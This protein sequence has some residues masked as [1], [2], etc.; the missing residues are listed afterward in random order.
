[1]PRTSGPP[2]LERLNERND[3]AKE[4]ARKKREPRQNDD[5][6]EFTIEAA[7]KH[8]A[9][10]PDDEARLE[11]VEQLR[12]TAESAEDLADRGEALLAAREIKAMCKDGATEPQCDLQLRES[13]EQESEI[14]D[15][16]WVKRE[17]NRIVDECNECEFNEDQRATILEPFA[18]LDKAVR[19]GGATR[20]EEMLR[21]WLAR[22]FWREF[23]EAAYYPRSRGKHPHTIS[24]PYGRKKTV[25]LDTLDLGK[26]SRLSWVAGL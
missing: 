15:L 20:R 5:A 25:N 1:M 21:N 11:L 23:G 6:P 12:L 14:D 7:I 2:S 22:E 10:L 13:A 19:F 8:A 17:Y 9:T 24:A 18:R 4:R 3:S 26:A 16:T